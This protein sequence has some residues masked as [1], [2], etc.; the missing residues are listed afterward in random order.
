VKTPNN[1]PPIVIPTSID[2]RENRM[3]LP[4]CYYG[5]SGA[6]RRP[7]RQFLLRRAVPAR[8]TRRA[9]S[10]GTARRLRQTTRGSLSRRLFRPTDLII[11]PTAREL[12]FAMSVG[13][14]QRQSTKNSS[15]YGSSE[16]LRE[17]D[18]PVY[19]VA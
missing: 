15:Q 17:S 18:I 6:R 8:P 3:V 4:N 10:A 7:S 14:E 19:C 1:S 13:G 9:G 11:D 12:S 16:D 2:R 5:P